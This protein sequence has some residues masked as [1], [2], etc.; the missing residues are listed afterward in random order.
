[1]ADASDEQTWWCGLLSGSADPAL[2]IPD[3][4]WEPIVASALALDAP[5]L[6]DDLLPADQAALAIDEPDPGVDIFH[7]GH[8]PSD[9]DA[10]DGS[11][12]VGG[13]HQGFYVDAGGEEALDGFE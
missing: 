11:H 12:D 13:D 4:V 7:D 10:F 5:L 3:N 6:T 8:P 2:E 9:S 1:M